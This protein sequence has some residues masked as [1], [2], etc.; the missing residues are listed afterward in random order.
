MR[1]TITLVLSSVLQQDIVNWVHRRYVFLQENNAMIQCSFEVYG[2]T[3]T[4]PGLVCN[5]DFLKRIM[6]NVEVD[7]DRTDDEDKLV[8]QYSIFV[9]ICSFLLA[10]PFKSITYKIKS[11]DFFF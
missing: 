6:A 9:S 1:Q 11:C 5:D 2:I 4:N 3:K 7:S 10:F 8:N